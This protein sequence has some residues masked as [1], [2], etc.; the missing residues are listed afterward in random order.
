MEQW[1]GITC[2]EM[3]M[4]DG[5]AILL[6]TLRTVTFQSICHR[7][8]FESAAEWCKVCG[9]NAY[10]GA[11]ERFGLDSVLEELHGFTTC[12]VCEE[13]TV[14]SG[15]DDDGDCLESRFCPPVCSQGM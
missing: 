7:T 10:C 6:G 4:H 11:C 2:Y 1:R 9:K 15:E 14:Y 13:C 5:P 8:P 12:Y 3:D